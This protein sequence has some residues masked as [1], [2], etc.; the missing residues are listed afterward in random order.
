MLLVLKCLASAQG[1][2]VSLVSRK[3]QAGIQA[4]FQHAWALAIHGGQTISQGNWR[5]ARALP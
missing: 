3:Q 1:L 4:R 2:D 5:I